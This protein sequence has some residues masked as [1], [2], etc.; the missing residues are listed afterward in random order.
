MYCFVFLILSYSIFFLLKPLGIG[1]NQAAEFQDVWSAPRPKHLVFGLEDKS[2]TRHYVKQT[3]I[4]DPLIKRFSGY[5]SN[6]I[7]ASRKP[8]ILQVARK[9]SAQSPPT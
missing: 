5:E 3:F 1:P 8:L 7:P 6:T 2:I 9:T 4:G